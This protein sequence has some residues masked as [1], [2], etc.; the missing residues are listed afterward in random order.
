VPSHPASGM[1]QEV[2]KIPLGENVT[3]LFW[4]VVIGSISERIWA[5]KSRPTNCWIVSEAIPATLAASSPQMCGVAHAILPE[6]SIA[7]S[8][9]SRSK[10]A[11][12]HNLLDAGPLWSRKSGSV[13]LG[14]NS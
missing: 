14:V 4:I 8:A 7:L 12:R 2:V 6:T 3:G 5:F 1:E 9:A 11:D 13:I 10:V